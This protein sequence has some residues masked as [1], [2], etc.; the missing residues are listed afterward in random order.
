MSHDNEWTQTKYE[1]LM[2]ASKYL[3][4]KPKQNVSKRLMEKSEP[5]LNT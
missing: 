2:K 5:E 3:P 4:Q 1:F